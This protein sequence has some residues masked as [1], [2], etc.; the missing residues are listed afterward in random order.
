MT[1]IEDLRWQMDLLFRAY[2]LRKARKIGVVLAD[3]GVIYLS[4]DELDPWGTRRRVSWAQ[5]AKIVESAEKD[6]GAADG[7]AITPVPAEKAKTK[8]RVDNAAALPKR[9]ADWGAT[10]RAEWAALGGRPNA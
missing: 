10:R 7:Q 4:D 2:Q 6:A 9:F 1:T 5:L 3:C 8:R